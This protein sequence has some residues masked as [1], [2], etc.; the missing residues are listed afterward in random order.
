MRRALLGCAAAAALL[1]GPSRGAAQVALRPIDGIPW[2]AV[3]AA[4][5]SVRVGVGWYAGARATVAGTRG[6][7]LEVGDV[8]AAWSLDRV[9]LELGGTAWRVFT[10]DS[11]YAA[12]IAHAFPMDGRRRADTGGHRLGTIV[13]VTPDASPLD[14]VL[15][16]GTILPTT[17]NTQGLGLDQ[18]DFY[19]TVGGRWLRPRGRLELA[20]EAGVAI[21]STRLDKPEQVDDLMYSARAGWRARRGR[22]WLE[23]VGQH[24]TRRAA[25]LRGLEDL[26]ELRLITEL[27]D[28]RRLRVT[29]VRGLAQASPSFGV[30]VAAG[31]SF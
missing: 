26:S 5:A 1:A 27:G 24:D 9:V 4:G 14:A 29:L 3:G 11:T 23:T 21:L 19:G 10:D 18:T 30:S 25:E 13:R 28:R 12:P 2:E 16:F 20:A 8:T 17:D 15:R 31:A 22:A 7:L 6:S